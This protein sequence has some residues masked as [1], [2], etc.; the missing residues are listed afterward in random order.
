MKQTCLNILIL[1]CIFCAAVLIMCPV[2][3]QTITI[4]DH[5]KQL[6]D[7]NFEV[8]EIP[9]D[10]SG[11]NQI[12]LVNT[13]NSV[14]ATKANSSYI[15][16]YAPTR[17]DYLNHPDMVLPAMDAWVKQYF[18]TAIGIGIMCGLIFIAIF[19]RRR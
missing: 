17:L 16:D 14:F 3:A 12:A 8:Y 15:I 6:T 18:V 7:I 19:W 13:S 10:G 2:H 9:S 11:P 4:T 5:T 1:S